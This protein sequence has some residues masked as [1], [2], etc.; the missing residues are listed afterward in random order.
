MKGSTG[1]Y[2]SDIRISEAYSMC[3]VGRDQW[4]I[5]RSIDRKRLCDYTNLRLS[6]D[7]NGTTQ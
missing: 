4:M 7:L 2:V 5:N 1:S 3:A 6:G